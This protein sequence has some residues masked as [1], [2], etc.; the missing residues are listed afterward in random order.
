MIVKILWI[1][2][3]LPFIVLGTIHLLYTFFSTKLSARDAA[4]NEA[5]K[6]S[7]P[8]LTKQTTM[9]KAWTGFNASHSTGAMYIG[10][11]NMLLAIQY[12]GVLQQPLV[13]LLNTITVL[14][15]VWL[16]KKYWFSIP[17]RGMVIAAVCYITAVVISLCH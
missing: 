9:H 8:V 10:L 4:L 11:V 6:M 1:T 14:F 16:A 12:S 5:M 3:S 7:Y 17:L 2:G 13:M 15:Y